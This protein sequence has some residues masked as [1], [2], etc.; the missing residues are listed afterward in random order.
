MSAMDEETQLAMSLSI[1]QAYEE[2]DAQIR[3]AMQQSTAVGQ[4]SSIEVARAMALAARR[5]LDEERDQK[6]RKIQEDGAPSSLPA[7]A[8]AAVPVPLSI[9][10]LAAQTC[11]WLDSLAREPVHLGQ[12][13]PPWPGLLHTEAITRDWNGDV[14][15]LK[16]TVHNLH[17]INRAHEIYTIT[18]LRGQ[19]EQLTRQWLT[20]IIPRDFCVLW[21]NNR[22]TGA[23]NSAAYDFHDLVCIMNHKNLIANMGFGVGMIVAACN[24]VS[25]AWGAFERRRKLYCG[26]WLAAATV[27]ASFV[28]LGNII[29]EYLL[30]GPLCT[31]LPSTRL[32]HGLSSFDNN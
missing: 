6:R 29:A 14:L 12:L 30:P 20:D 21:T 28:D 2:E 19:L 27:G 23:P 8:D 17:P 5:E 10:A 26:Q 4:Q 13:Q 18:H 31:L 16:F 3:L 32:S 7:A 22:V 25:S 15:E 24:R 11:A 1:S 9:D